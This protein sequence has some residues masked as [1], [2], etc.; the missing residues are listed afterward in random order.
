[1]ETSVDIFSVDLH[2][3]THRTQAIVSKHSGNCQS[4]RFPLVIA[5]RTLLA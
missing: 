3:P 5:F 2:T 4:S 1:M